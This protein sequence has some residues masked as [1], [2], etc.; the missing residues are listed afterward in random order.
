MAIWQFCNAARFGVVFI[1]LT[2]CASTQTARLNAGNPEGWDKLDAG[3]FSVLAP[4]G[5]EFHQLT[6]ADSYVGEF[7]GNG[8]TRRS[9]PTSS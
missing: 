7:V 3:P 1:L 9:Q 2:V 6:G 8:V 4:S 5:W